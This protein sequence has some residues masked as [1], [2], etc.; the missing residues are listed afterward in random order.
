VKR[1]I[2]VE[3]TYGV[4]FHRELLRKM[5]VDGVEVHRLPTGKCDGALERKVKARIVGVDSFKIVFVVDRE[6]RPVGEA[7]DS[8]LRHLTD[9]LLRGNTRIVVVDPRHEAWLCIGL[10]LDAAKCRTSPEEAIQRVRGEYDKYRL[11]EWARYV[12]VRHLA[13]EPD[14]RDYAD[15]IRWLR[16]DP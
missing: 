13:G 6:N 11:G 16:E 12:D 5:G 10:G 14:F 15:A 9:H 4:A 3:D 7:R 1:L 2:F 8:L